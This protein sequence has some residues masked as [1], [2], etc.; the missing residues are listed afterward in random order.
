VVL[1]INPILI[2]MY[3]L[4][5]NLNYKLPCK[6]KSYVMIK[7]THC[8]SVILKETKETRELDAIWDTS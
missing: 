3:Q 2:F 1:G 5:T 8:E 4:K 6:K 7:R